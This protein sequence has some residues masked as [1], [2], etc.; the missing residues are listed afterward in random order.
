MCGIAG[1]LGPIQSDVAAVL[2]SLSASLVHR[3]PDDLGFLQ[4]DGN[5]TPLVGRRPRDAR[6]T[7]V[8]LIVRRLSI[9][10]LSETGRQPMSSPDGRYHIVFNGEIYN[11]VELQRELAQL[12]HVFRGHSDTEVLLHAFSEWGPACVHRLVGMFAYCVL[13]TR[14]RR[15]HFARDPFG[16]KPLYFLHRPTGLAFASEIPTLLALPGFRP[17]LH[18]G[19]VADYL[20]HG[21]TDH[22]PETMVDGVTHLPP[23]HIATADLARPTDLSMQRYWSP[24]G[25]RHG[26]PPSFDEASSSIRRQLVESVRLHLRSD[27]PIGI[28]LSGGIDSSTITT[29]VRHLEPELSLHTFSYVADDPHLSEQRWIDVVA[30]RVGTAPVTVGID[31]EHLPARLDW[32]IRAQGEP[33][34]NLGIVAQFAVFEAAARAGIRVVL[35]GQGADELFAGYGAYVAG[36]CAS[37]LNHGHLVG[38]LRLASRGAGRPGSE[39]LVTTL[40]RAALPSMPF[41]LGDR[42]AWLSGQRAPKWLRKRW[43]AERGVTMGQGRFG[44][45]ERRSLGSMLRYDLTVAG[46]PALLRY[47]DR[48]SMAVSVES[49]LPYLTPALADQV[50]ALPESYMI[51]EDGRLFTKRVL[52]S[53]ARGLVPD[54]VLERQDKLGYTTPEASMLVYLGPWV[55]EVLAALPDDLSQPVDATAALGRWAAVMAGAQPVKSDWRLANFVRWSQL[56]DVASY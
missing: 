47:E 1:I 11:Y 40:G 38:A 7:L 42:M 50:L 10:D 19:A 13:D 35:S 28:A 51:G 14:A 6:G 16:I 52:R 30:R 18:P 43:F 53:A 8:A 17:R 12:G 23:A 48:N 45:P 21:L 56:M 15:L 36:R 22:R 34:G 54:E 32:L 27:V 26:L 25:V 2:E 55:K 37:L 44:A 9:I 41:G 39:G 33:F 20:A 4:W 31:R 3:G 46:L 24:I 5:G 49:R 29:L